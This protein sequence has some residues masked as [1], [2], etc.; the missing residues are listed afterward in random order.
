MTAIKTAFA[1]AMLVVVAYA[2]LL[3]G[4][5]WLMLEVRVGA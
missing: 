2:G 4:F 5:L 3:A 1:I